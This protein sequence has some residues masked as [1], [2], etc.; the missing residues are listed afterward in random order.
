[1][2]DALSKKAV[3]QTS[4]FSFLLALALAQVPVAFIYLKI[5]KQKALKIIKDVKKNI[6][7]YKHPILGSFFHIIGT[8]LLLLSFNYTMASI[9]SPITATSG[10]ILIL[11]T[12]LF[13]DEK[14]RFK[15]FIGII[16]AFIGV[17]G[18]SFV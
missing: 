7:E 11:L 8:G 12:V 2:S 9:A 3:D 15:N 16:L 4:S 5:E 18:L 10:V 6:E 1:M 13:M 17:L 14:I